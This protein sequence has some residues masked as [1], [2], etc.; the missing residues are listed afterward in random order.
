VGPGKVSDA[1]C[2]KHS[3]I[4]DFLLCGGAHVCVRARACVRVYVCVR[5]CVLLIVANKLEMI[6]VSQHLC[7]DAM[8][9]QSVLLYWREGTGF[10]FMWEEQMEWESSLLGNIRSASRF[11]LARIQLRTLI[12]QRYASI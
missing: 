7:R 8:C 1:T 6:I 4:I 12:N 10:Y 9:G 3:C 2:F 5:A 11:T